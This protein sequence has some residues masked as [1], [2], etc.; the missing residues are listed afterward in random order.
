[1]NEA[2]VLVIEA[3]A[4][5]PELLTVTVLAVCLVVMTRRRARLPSKQRENGSPVFMVLIKRMTLAMI[6]WWA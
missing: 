3:L 5:R 1:M 4:V 2:I 6:C